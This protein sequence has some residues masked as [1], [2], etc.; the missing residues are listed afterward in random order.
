MC[1]ETIAEYVQRTHDP[2]PLKRRQALKEL[3]PCHVRQDIPEVWER[4]FQMLSDESSI[5]RDQVC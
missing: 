2:N 5:V 1:D 4:V 3:C